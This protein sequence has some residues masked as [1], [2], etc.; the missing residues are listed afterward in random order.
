MANMETKTINNNNKNKK[1]EKI[2]ESC[3]LHISIPPKS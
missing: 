1:T 3:P 2:C